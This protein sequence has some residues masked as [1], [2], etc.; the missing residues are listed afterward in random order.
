MDKY[1]KDWLKKAESDFKV[2]EHEM[3]LESDEVVKDAV[4]F[5]CQQAI[6]KYLKAVMI[7]DN[8]DVPRTHSIE[9]LI[10][11]VS[12]KHP[13]FGTLKLKDISM[14]GV[15]YRYPDNYY[16]PPLKEVIFYVE[17]ANSIKK[18]SQKIIKS[19]K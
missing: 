15:Q 10:Q 16:V 1:V 13:E 19:S 5:H 9:Y 12:N 6:E 18:I 8:I 14:F 17:L 4:C 11:K 7:I 3:S 2:I